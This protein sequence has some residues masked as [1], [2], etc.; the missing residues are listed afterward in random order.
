MDT[1]LG[2]DVTD[3]GLSYIGFIEREGL[4]DTRRNRGLHNL[5]GESAHG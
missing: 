5:P 4:E 1:E 2:P 3:E